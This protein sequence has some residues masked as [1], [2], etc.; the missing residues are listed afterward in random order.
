M[1]LEVVS[2]N[3]STP[4]TGTPPRDSIPQQIII[5]YGSMKRAYGRTRLTGLTYLEVLQLIYQ[6]FSIPRHH[7]LY[8]ALSVTFH[9]PG[10]SR[11][12]RNEGPV[13][14]DF[15][16]WDELL[17]NVVKVDVAVPRRQEWTAYVHDFL[18]IYG[19]WCLLTML[20]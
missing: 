17:H 20:F 10:K 1:V 9:S 4:T 11:G 8:T 3:S 2:E 13:S 15:F 14:V 18:I 19:A 16:S 6:D 5:T 12:G 7:S